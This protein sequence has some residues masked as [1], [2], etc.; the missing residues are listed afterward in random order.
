MSLVVQLADALRAVVVAAETGLPIEPIL[1]KV[2]ALLAHADGTNGCDTCKQLEAERQGLVDERR[3]A[4]AELARGAELLEQLAEGPE[5]P[6]R[7]LF[8][9]GVGAWLRTIARKPRV[10]GVT[11]HVLLSELRTLAEALAERS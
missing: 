7:A 11:R 1:P 2:K 4:Y 3:N 10:E 8:L 6:G 5:L 9:R